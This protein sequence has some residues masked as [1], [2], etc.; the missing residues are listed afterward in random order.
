MDLKCFRKY[1]L[2]SHVISLLP[3]VLNMYACVL[4]TVHTIQPHNAKEY[5][6]KYLGSDLRLLCPT[7]CHRFIYH[8]EFSNFLLVQ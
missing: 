2:M 4:Y 8:K 6:L 1:L 3:L 7:N 5:G